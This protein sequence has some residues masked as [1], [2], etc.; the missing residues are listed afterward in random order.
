MKPPI[1]YYGSKATIA[2]RIVA[3]LPE[4]QHY[5]EP[6]CGSLSVLLAKQP[7]KL[8]TV[9]DIDRDLMLFWRVVRDRYD[10]LA[11]KVGLT[12]HS[13]AEHLEAYADTDDELERAR[14]VWVMLTQGRSGT[15][16]KTGWRH[17]VDPHG[18]SIPMSGYLEAYR[19]RLPP[20]AERLMDVSLECL[21]ALDIIAKYGA[22]ED[23]LLY[24]D[25]PYVGSAR[26]RNY[27]HEMGS[28]ADH[29]ELAEAL[30]ANQSAVVL[31]GYHS[32]LYDEIYRG[33]HVH[34]IATG[35]GQGGSYDPRTEVLWSN[36][37]LGMQPSL[38]DAADL[39]PAV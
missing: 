33:W 3:L 24:V 7:S 22:H 9:N 20:A 4:H 6:Y 30:C 10:E 23:V 35:T 36:R 34:E 1:G 32:P 25:P 14:R 29:R 18:T 38:F 5:V 8:E 27:R 21:P 26:A 31:S 13:R 39:S 17:Y 37:P 28:D 12:P 11:D 2:E 16:R 19:R 15:M